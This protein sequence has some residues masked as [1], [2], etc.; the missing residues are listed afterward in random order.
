MQ[1]FHCHGLPIF[2]RPLLVPP[3][4]SCGQERRIRLPA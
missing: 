2:G 1:G 4:A 3:S